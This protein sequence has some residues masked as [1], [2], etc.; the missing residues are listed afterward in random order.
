MSN[1]IWMYFWRSQ[2]VTNARLGVAMGR[3]I[4]M[5][6]GHSFGLFDASFEFA[7]AAEV[8]LVELLAVLRARRRFIERASSR[9]K[10]RIDFCSYRRASKFALRWPGAPEPKSRSNA[11]RGFASGGIGVVGELHARLY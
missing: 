1:M 4:G 5:R 11:R 6:L 8:Y 10:S 9:A 2:T 7:D 3:V